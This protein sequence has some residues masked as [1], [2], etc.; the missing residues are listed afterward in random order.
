MPAVVELQDARMRRI[1]DIQRA[2][3]IGGYAQRAGKMALRG[4][5][6][7]LKKR[8][9]GEKD[10]NV[11]PL[12]VSQINGAA[13]VHRDPRRAADTRV[14]KGL[15]GNAAR[16]KFVDKAAR[17]GKENIAKGICCESHRRVQFARALAFISP[18]A[19]ELKWRRRLRLRRRTYTVSTGNK[20][21]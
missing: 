9:I 20:E 7:G 1:G 17:V 4:G 16:F 5:P 2:L 12:S 19:Q 14:L 15:Q 18:G 11:A 6:P 21:K 13:R 10:V 3:L 8:P